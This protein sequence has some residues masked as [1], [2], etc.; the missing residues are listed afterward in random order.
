MVYEKNVLLL[1]LDYD[2]RPSGNYDEVRR[3]EQIEEPRVIQ[4]L[5]SDDGDTSVD[6]A[7]VNSERKKLIEEAIF[8]YWEESSKDSPDIQV[9]LDSLEQAVTLMWDVVS[10]ED[11]GS[12]A[13]RTAEAETDNSTSA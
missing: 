11:V 10:G 4:E 3:D 9:Q 1:P 7:L 5:V 2:R 8:D 13:Q 6:R 12:E